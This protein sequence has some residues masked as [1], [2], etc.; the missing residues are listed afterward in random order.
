M[1]DPFH[2]APFQGIASTRRRPPTQGGRTR[3]PSPSPAIDL[4][5]T[6]RQKFPRLFNIEL[7]NSEQSGRVPVELTSAWERS[8]CQQEAQHDRGTAKRRADQSGKEK[9]GPGRRRISTPKS[10]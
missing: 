9:P 10:S 6:T 1:I 3:P 2:R 5:K 4:H 8:E 7:S